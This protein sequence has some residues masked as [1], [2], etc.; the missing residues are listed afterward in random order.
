VTSTVARHSHPDA[1]ALLLRSTNVC[2][3]AIASSAKRKGA[4]GQESVLLQCGLA[5]DPGGARLPR[6][7][8][9]CGRIRRLLGIDALQTELR[10]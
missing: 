10:M 3:E 9:S 2:S 1:H 7:S 6:S 4:F 8:D 5:N